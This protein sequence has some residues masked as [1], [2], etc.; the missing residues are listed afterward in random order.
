VRKA[1]PRQVAVAAI[2][3]MTA[4]REITAGC[5][6][7]YHLYRQSG[8]IAVHCT[9]ESPSSTSVPWRKDNISVY[10]AIDCDAAHEVRTQRV[11]KQATASTGGQALSNVQQV[12]AHNSRSSN[13]TG[14]HVWLARF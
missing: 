12:I 5:G 2:A 10:S 11:N 8:N 4:T 13:V 14:H 9:L 6:S 3:C 7:N 1:I